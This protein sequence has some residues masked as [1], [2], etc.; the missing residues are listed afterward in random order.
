MTVE[1]FFR[2]EGIDLE[3]VSEMEGSY[4]EKCYNFL[5]DV[6]EKDIK[7][8][9]PKQYQ[10]AQNIRED[11]AE[12]NIDTAAIINRYKASKKS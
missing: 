3:F 10:W 2:Q 4:Y 9:S 5:A 12:A 8:L 11:C 7:D 6:W 1:E